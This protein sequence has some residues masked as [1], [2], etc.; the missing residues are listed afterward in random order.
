MKSEEFAAAPKTTGIPEG[1]SSFFTLHSS[2][3][4]D[5]AKDDIH[6]VSDFGHADRLAGLGVLGGGGPSAAW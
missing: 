3:K 2:L 1:N 6:S 5:E 4:E